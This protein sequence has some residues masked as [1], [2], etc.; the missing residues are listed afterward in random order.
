[1]NFVIFV[2][3]LIAFA[4]MVVLAVALWIYFEM[5][6]KETAKGHKQDSSR[7]DDTTQG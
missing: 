5:R 1:M 7:H 4:G 6:K 2:I 3:G